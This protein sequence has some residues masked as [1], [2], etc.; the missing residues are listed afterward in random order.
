MGVKQ[1]DKNYFYS[2][3]SLVAGRKAV[4]GYGGT[5][6]SGVRLAERPGLSSACHI[7]T[8]AQ[9]LSSCLVYLPPGETKATENFFLSL[10]FK[11][12]NRRKC[13]LEKTAQKHWL[14]L[15]LT[16]SQS[17]SLSVLNESCWP[18]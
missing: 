11:T 14:Q 15:N 12:K 17:P 16:M 9:K 4:F 6:V 3:P 18:G 13:V 8:E 1:K 10:F 5:W 7:I 2:Q